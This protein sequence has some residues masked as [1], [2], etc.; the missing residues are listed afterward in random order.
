MP[1]GTNP[2]GDGVY[3]G[4]GGGVAMNPFGDDDRGGGGT[5]PFDNDD[6]DDRRGA[7][8]AGM[9]PFDGGGGPAAFGMGPAAEEDDWGGG[10]G[11]G[12]DPSVAAELA[13]PNAPVE[14]S[15]QFLGDLPY[16]RV[17]MYDGI[18]WGRG[19]SGGKDGPEE[20]GR[21]VGTDGTLGGF[22]LAAF[23][24]RYLEAYA[25]RAA[26]GESILD[27]SDFRRLLKTATVTRVAGC[28]NGGPVA[29]ITLPVAGTS[30]PGFGSV[31]SDKGARG[32]SDATSAL[33]TTQLRILS[34]SGRTIASVDFPP[35]S[36]ALTYRRTY[37]AADVL[38]IGFTDRCV[39]L[40]VM[41]DSLILTYDMQ[42]KQVLPPFHSL[43]KGDDPDAKVQ[44]PPSGRGGMGRELMQAT[45]YGGGCAVLSTSMDSAVVEMLDWHDDPEYLE[46][47]ALEARR[48]VPEDDSSGPALAAVGIDGIFGTARSGPLP[49]H[50]ALV[51]P[52]ATAVHSSRNYYSYCTV[53]VLPRAHTESRRPEVFLSTSDNSVVIADTAGGGITDVDCRGRVDSPIVA[54]SFAPNGR[55]LACFTRGCILLVISTNFETKVLDFDTS[56]G[57]RDSPSEMEWCGE[58]R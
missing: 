29:A 11:N 18:E 36:L 37:T 25:R 17:V 27:E 16:R 54:M 52:L 43:P 31:T 14:A 41:R 53:A 39:L 55:F 7:G 56:V 47:A 34:S 21:G 15:W 23:P 30:L 40:V 58:D 19:P 24:P 57:S 38:E 12:A 45:V 51:T 5:N 48:I 44:G 32:A 10:N 46:G 20:A 4:G 9:K 49:R 42:G 8:G 33:S 6:G 13:D 26:A 35:P 2:F 50:V 1:V 28:P 3:D 22:G